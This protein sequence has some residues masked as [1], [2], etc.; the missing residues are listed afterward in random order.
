[1]NSKHAQD[2]V[3]KAYQDMIDAQIQEAK[4]KLELVEATARQKKAQAEI[5]VITS[6]MTA[7]QNLEARTRNLKTLHES[8]LS[9]AKAEIAGDVAKF[10]TSIDE[11]AAR[12]KAGPAKK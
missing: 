5:A 4:A 2:A 9:R 10:R 3:I 12:L 8:N 7:R 6:L 11:L 1:M